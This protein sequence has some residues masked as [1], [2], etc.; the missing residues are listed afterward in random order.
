M[1]GLRFVR[2]LFSRTVNALTLF[3][4]DSGLLGEQKRGMPD[5]RLKE[6]KYITAEEGAKSVAKKTARAKA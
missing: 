2:F 5:L 6:N 3:C 4:V 1:T